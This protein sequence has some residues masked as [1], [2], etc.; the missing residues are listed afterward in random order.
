MTGYLPIFAQIGGEVEVNVN[1]LSFS[2]QNGY[3]VIRWNGGA[4]KIRQTGAPELPVIL[5]TY[6]IPLE[7]RLTGIDVS[8]S[9]RMPVD[10]TF[11]PY[12]VQQ[13]IPIDTETG[14]VEFTQ[15]DTS[16]YQGTEIYPKAKAQI[17]ADYNEMGF[18]LVT[19]QLHPVEYDPVS[20]QLFVSRLNFSLQY[21]AGSDG[22]QSQQQSV[23]RANAIKKVIRSMVDNPENVDGFTNSKVKL[24]GGIMPDVQTRAA[25]SSMSIDVIQEQVPDYIIITNNELRSEFQRLA[26]WKTQKG[27]PTLIKDVESIGQEYQ[28]SDLAEKVHFYLQE[29]Y[30]KWGAGLFVLLGGDTNIVPERL[31][32]STYDAPYGFYP[33]D[34]YYVDLNSSWNA[35]KNHLYRE[36]GDGMKKDRLCYLGRA[37]V[38]NA[39]EA[40]NFINKVLLYEKME[41]VNTNYLM[42]HLAVSAYISKDEFT[43]KLDNDGKESINDYLSQYPQINKWYLFDHYNCTCSLHGDKTMYHSGQ[44]L[45]KAH[46]LSALQDGGD[47]GLDHFHI[48]YHMDHSH[49]SALGTSSKDK[50]ESIYIQDVDNLNNGDYPLIM[51]S[52][53]CKPARFTEDCI[54]EHFLTNPL[55]GAVAFIGNGDVGWSTEYK[56]YKKFLTS[57]YDDGFQQLGVLFGSMFQNYRDDYYR[58]HLLGD[59][60]MP[61]WSAVP[62][63]LEVNVTPSQIEAGTNTITVQIS[64]LPAGEEATVCLMKD[65]EAYTVVT[66]NDT[67]PHS[68][69]F[70]PKT[71]GEMAVTVTAHNFIPFEK[72]VLVSVNN[73]NLLSIE[74]INNFGGY[75]QAGMEPDFD[76]V[77]KNNGKTPARNVTVT[78]TSTSPYVEILNGT[79]DYG[80][81]NTGQAKSGNGMFRVKISTGAPEVTRNE[82]NAPC[83]YLTM[84]KDGTDMADVDTF[85]VDLKHYKFRIA[86]LSLSSNS[87]LEPGGRIEMELNVENL[88][89]ITPSALNWSITPLAPSKVKVDWVASS[90]CI[91]TL[92]EDYVPESSWPSM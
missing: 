85:K 29:C 78:L 66:V 75:V 84:K 38:E 4:D 39:E 11:T 21:M 80:T 34:A 22:I 2:R 87:V 15:P 16:I 81:I 69:T 41:N 37:S 74:S 68:F 79:I 48:V 91:C 59:P 57:L 32:W 54:A 44:E 43:G 72:T 65:A 77:L 24:V 6:V 60:E 18:H 90:T 17:V 8:V 30:R 64:N 55:G 76:I 61:V 19:V 92:S 73:G 56:Q 62:Q 50:H 67:K 27:V 40:K 83:F 20:H 1:E 42:N 52:G 49:P 86:S 70:T 26:N 7:A 5:K 10:G 36:T 35:N 82:W 33:S 23:R 31:Y 58:L 45:N 53:G 63:E 88:G 3:D 89:N 71:P 51:I 14:G 46:F 47:S 25:S 9:N 13:P 12:P 28:G